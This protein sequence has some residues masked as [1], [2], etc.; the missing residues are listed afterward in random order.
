MIAREVCA[1][2][3]FRVDD[4]EWVVLKDPQFTDE[5]HVWFPV[6][7]RDGQ[8]PHFDFET[9]E[10]VAWSGPWDVDLDVPTSA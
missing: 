10:G 5:D 4:V 3:F 2:D 8:P 9:A 1:G 6:A 7:R